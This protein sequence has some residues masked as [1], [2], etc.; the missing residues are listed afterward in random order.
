MKAMN[1]IPQ[2]IK[3]PPMC[4]ISPLVRR[5]IHTKKNI[6]ENN[7]DISLIDTTG[8]KVPLAELI[9]NKTVCRIFATIT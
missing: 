6:I 4:A 5:C 3:L 2:M 9:K 8:K 1:R 7:N